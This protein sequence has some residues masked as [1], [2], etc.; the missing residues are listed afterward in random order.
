M[1]TGCR[2]RPPNSSGHRSY[3]GGHRAA[4]LTVFVILALTGLYLDRPVKFS[5]GSENLGEKQKLAQTSGTS[6]QVHPKVFTNITDIS[7]T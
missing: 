1:A 5:S 4:L 2:V 6:L 7:V 3:R